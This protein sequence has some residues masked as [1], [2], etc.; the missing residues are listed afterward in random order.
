M[1]VAVA[2]AAIYPQRAERVAY[3]GVRAEDAL[4]R[5]A[6]EVLADLGYARP[7]VVAR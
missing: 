2:A 6:R 5:G 3:R 7:E 4:S 1:L